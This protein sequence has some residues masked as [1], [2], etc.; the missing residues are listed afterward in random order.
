MYR[1]G[2][3][4]QEWRKRCILLLKRPFLRDLCGG[5]KH[6]HYSCLMPIE[7]DASSDDPRIRTKVILP[8]GI[9]EDNYSGNIRTIIFSSESAGK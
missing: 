3:R 5:C 9:A 2:F 8:E 6:A 7:P 1:A 4:R